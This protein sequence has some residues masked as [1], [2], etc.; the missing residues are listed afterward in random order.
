MQRQDED[1]ATLIS[2]LYERKLPKDKNEASKILKMEGQ[3]VLD[4]NGLGIQI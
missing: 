2:Y 3:F 1:L 4:T